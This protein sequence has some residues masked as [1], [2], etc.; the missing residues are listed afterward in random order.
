MQGVREN[1]YDMIQASSSS[2]CY[3]IRTNLSYQGS[4]VGAEVSSDPMIDGFYSNRKDAV[5]TARS[6]RLIHFDSAFWEKGKQTQVFA[7]PCP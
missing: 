1:R 5:A 4:I 3:H 6:E 7:K 2:G